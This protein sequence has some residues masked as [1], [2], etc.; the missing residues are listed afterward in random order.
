MTPYVGGPSIELKEF[1]EAE[2]RTDI[3]IVAKIKGVPF[4]TLTWCKA[5]AHKA[6]EKSKVEY[7]QHVNKIVTEDKCTLLIHQSLRKDTGLYTLT[8]T[9]NLGTDSKEMRLNVLGRPGPPVGPIK[10]EG[11]SAEHITLAWLPPKDD[12]GSKITNYVVEKREANRKTWMEV[13]NEVKECLCSVPKLLEGHEYVFR[14]MAQ[15][16]YGVGEPLDSE[17]ETARNLFTLPGACDKPTISSVTHDSMI[18][19]W[20]DP[21]YD[22]GSPVTGYWLERKET[23]GKRWNRVNRDPIRIMPLGVS[24]N[25]TGLIEGSNYQFRVF[26]INAAGIGPPSQPS[27]PTIARDPIAPPGPPFPKV[28]DWT[29]STA[30]VEWDPPTKDGGSRITGYFVEFKEEGK[31]EWEKVSVIDNA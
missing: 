17:P 7:D 24:Y 13:T 1:L 20:E 3:S 31:E 6:E 11:I 29:K 8:A 28:T 16:K 14:I 30:D 4:P 25:V 27:D 2:E 22:G 23:T 26:A 19:N 18:V 9:N 21:E 12:G 5:P 15:N 10:F